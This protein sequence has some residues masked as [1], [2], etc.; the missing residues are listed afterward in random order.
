[1]LGEHNAEVLRELG[2]AAED[3]AA[4]TEERAK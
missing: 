1:M 2:Y 4:L 3:V